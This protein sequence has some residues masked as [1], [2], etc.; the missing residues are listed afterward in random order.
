MRYHHL[1]VSVSLLSRLNP[2][3]QPFPPFFKINY[4]RQTLQGHLRRSEGPYC[5]KSWGIM[6]NRLIQRFRHTNSQFALPTFDPVN[7]DL[8]SGYFDLGLWPSCS[9][10]SSGISDN[11]LQMTS[12]QCI[13]AP[14]FDT[15]NDGPLCFDIDLGLWPSYSS[16]TF[17]ISDNALQITGQ[18]RLLP[19][20]NP[21]HS[22]Y[23]HGKLMPH[24]IQKFAQYLGVLCP[25]VTYDYTLDRFLNGNLPPLLANSIAALAVEYVCLILPFILKIYATLTGRYSD[26]PELVARGLGNVSWQYN[27]KAKVRSRVI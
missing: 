11:A 8:L 23:P 10:G 15:V 14:L 6:L 24:F 12:Q 17:G 4:S 16:G 26:L 21:S 27:E 20:F 5:V 3:L 22:Q 19:L 2:V 7:D 1:K 18:H 13:P 25:F 9:L